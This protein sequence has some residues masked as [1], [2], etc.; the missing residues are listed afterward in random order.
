MISPKIKTLLDSQEQS[1]AILAVQLLRAVEKM[2]F[3]EAILYAFD[4]QIGQ[5][6][7]WK[8]E[9]SWAWS[10]CLGNATFF[11]TGMRSSKVNFFFHFAV[12]SSYPSSQHMYLSNMPNLRN[13]RLSDAAF[14]HHIPRM[15]M[16]L[17]TEGYKLIKAY[18]EFEN[19]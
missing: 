12:Q 17:A 6:I 19:T 9:N 7:Q 11:L 8:I 14:R 16:W 1:N 18:W 15:R 3:K 4:H 5:N 13:N 2:S 10:I